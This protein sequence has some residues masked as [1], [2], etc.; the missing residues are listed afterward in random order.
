MALRVMLLTVAAIV[1]MIVEQALALVA[2]GTL[3]VQVVTIPT[4]AKEP[5][6]R[7]IAQALMAQ[8]VLAQHRAAALTTKP[9]ATLN[10]VAP[11]RPELH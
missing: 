3:A 4:V 5:M 2:R 8:R 9:T 1:R 7:G 10:Q 11:G 6:Q